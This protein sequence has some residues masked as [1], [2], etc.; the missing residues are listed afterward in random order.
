MNTWKAIRTALVGI[1][2]GIIGGFGICTMMT[3]NKVVNRVEGGQMIEK[4]EAAYISGVP[5]AGTDYMVPY[6]E[7]FLNLDG[8][9]DRS[10]IE[11]ALAEL[12]DNA[13]ASGNNQ[14]EGT[15]YNENM[16]IAEESIRIQDKILRFHVKANSNSKEDLALKYEVRDAVLSYISD[17]LDEAESKL[18]AMDILYRY[19]PEIEAEVKKCIQ[20]AGYDYDAEVSVGSSYFPMRQYGDLVLPAGTYDALTIEIGEAKGEN[21]WCMLY[22]SICFTTDSAAVVDSQSKEALKEVLT[23][24]EYREV[25]IDTQA[26]EEGRVKVSF[27]FLSLFK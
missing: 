4:A 19:T 1:I 27:R 16:Q 20:E 23:E 21:F 26:R 12:D 22:P 9:L 10:T 11:E 5:N 25:F 6:T 13:G 24:E 8:I 3:I 17:K 14:A 18:S 15:P 2:I 7:G